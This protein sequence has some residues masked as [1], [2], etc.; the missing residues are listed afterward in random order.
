MDADRSRARDVS[1]RARSVL[2]FLATRINTHKEMQKTALKRFKANIRD[3]IDGLATKIDDL[4]DLSNDLVGAHVQINK[5][6]DLLTS[7]QELSSCDPGQIVNELTRKCVDKP[8]KD[9]VDC[10]TEKAQ[11]ACPNGTDPNPLV[12]E[13]CPITCGMNL[14]ATL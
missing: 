7:T 5:K 9:W 4:Y 1:V 10:E 13:F 6:L 14:P 11:G 8:W 12:A 2:F 3:R